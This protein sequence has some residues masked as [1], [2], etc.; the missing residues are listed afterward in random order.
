[1]PQWVDCNYLGTDRDLAASWR[2]IEAA[3]ELGNQR[4]F[5]SVRAVELV[6][7]PKARPT[8]FREF[9]RLASGSYQHPWHC[10]MGVD[11]LSVVDPTLRVNG[12]QGLRVAMPR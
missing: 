7:G 6:P 11:H 2:A 4:A 5:D 9:A 10:K 12:L 8:T 3:R 1:M